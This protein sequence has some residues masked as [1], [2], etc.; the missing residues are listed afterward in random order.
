MPT[1]PLFRINRTLPA[2]VLSL[3]VCAPALA[4]PEYSLNFLP[5]G[6]T[7]SAIN[8]GGQIV[9]TYDG[10][11]AILGSGGITSLA[12]VAPGS[13]GL[14]ISDNGA[15][16]GAFDSPQSGAAFI[17]RAGTLTEISPLLGDAY[18]LSNARAINDSGVAVGIAYPFAGD[19]VRGYVYENGGV[20]LIPTFGGSWSNALA[21][22]A[23]GAVA[24][25]ASIA[26]I[27]NDVM[28][29]E[30]HAYID[31]GGVIQ[32]LGT[33]GG[34]RSEGYDI[35]DAGEVVGWS[36]AAGPTDAALA[37][38]FL[39]SD[40]VM[41]DL[42]SLGGDAGYAR[43]L[44]NLGLVVGESALGGAGGSHAFLYLDGQLVDL[45]TLVSGADGWELV[46][47]YDINDAGQILGRACQGGECV[48]VRLDLV[49]AVPEPG[50]WAL[51]LGGL[52]WVLRRRAGRL[53]AGGQH[54]N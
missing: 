4:D 3:C 5:T 54:R 28:D 22:N 35:N 51:L 34:L 13:Y 52:P 24:G 25:T 2:L 40:G 48:D 33:L 9:G 32:D 30:R 49:P 41:L 26:P 47:A 8:N 44:N 10:A 11:A 36:N 15:V 17:Y 21:V 7:A 23:S 45:N 29:L 46:N 6:F 53:A 14:G 16:A 42:G 43:A 18:P 12:S 19:A 39:Y 38:P 37:H 50:A 1:L 20:R 31:R 27:D